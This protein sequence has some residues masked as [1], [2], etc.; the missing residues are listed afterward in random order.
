MTDLVATFEALPPPSA[1][2]AITTFAEQGVP[3]RVGK[4]AE[5][6]AAI[7]YALDGLRAG[8]EPYELRH[9]RY[10]PSVTAQIEVNGASR[11]GHF[12]IV[13]CKADEPAM[14]AHFLRLMGAILRHEDAVA[15]PSQ[16]D[17]AIKVLIRMFR[18]MGR[19][20]RETV[21]G[22]W[23]EL[24]LIAWSRDASDAVAAWHSLAGET[25]DF[26]SGVSRL[27]VKSTTRPYREHEL[28]LDQ[29][30]V[31]PEGHTLLASLLLQE[32]DEGT[33]IQDLVDRIQERLLLATETERLVGIVAECLGSDWRQAE[34]RRFDE[35]SAR[36]SLR[37]YESH[38]VPSVVRDVPAQVSRVR[39][40]SDLSG[41]PALELSD[42]RALTHFYDAVLPAEDSPR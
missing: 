19:P 2:A 40:A 35:A 10:R 23:A 38:R 21:Q 3:W 5:G 14:T 34:H 26:R 24:A 1:A 33:S 7:L 18:A 22:T 12:A 30:I 39:F 36:A 4:T 41:T 17:D 29:L 32:D 6:D 37:I 8:A 9:L 42:A 20:A 31:E 25:V 27:E 28:S 15:L 16:F 13:S 11:M